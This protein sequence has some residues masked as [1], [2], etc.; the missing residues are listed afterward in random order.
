MWPPEHAF[1]TGAS[2]GIGRALSILLA[3]AGCGGLTLV[4]RNASRLAET[5]DMCRSK[6]AETRTL[7]MDVRDREGMVLA[8]GDTFDRRPVDLV[9]ANAGVSGTLEGDPRAV[10]DINIGGVLNSVE[11][12]IEPMCARGQGQI[13]IMSSIAGFKGF[14][15]APLYCASKAAVRSYGEALDAR[16]RPLGVAV[17][18]LCPGFIETPLTAV[19]AF[20]MPLIMSSEAAARR[21]LGGI[22]RRKARVAFP[23]RMYAIVRLLECLPTGLANTLLA[24]TA[25]RR[26]AKE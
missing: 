26:A 14:P 1:L 4:G 18:V 25:G 16:L 20:P 19:N 23:L 3:E 6:G 8:A 22:E 24:R 9:I 13:A 12:F 15:N 2:S 21:L 11:P 10:L 5:A 17:T 7:L